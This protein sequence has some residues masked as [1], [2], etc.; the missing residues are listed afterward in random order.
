M[1]SKN[2]ITELWQAG[3]EFREVAAIEILKDFGNHAPLFFHLIQEHR[4]PLC[5][6]ARHLMP[7]LRKGYGTPELHENE[8]DYTLFQ[9]MNVLFRLFFQRLDEYLISHQQEKQ[10]L[11]NLLFQ[12]FEGIRGDLHKKYGLPI[13]IDEHEVAHRQL[14]VFVTGHCNLHCA[15][16]FSSNI[17]HREIDASA[18]HDIFKWAD[19]QKVKSITPCG[20]EPLMYQHFQLFLNL[21]KEYGMTTYF[22]TNFTIDIS[23]LEHFNQ[24]VIKGVYI[25]LTTELLEDEKLKKVVID[26]IHIAK[27]RRIEL[28]GRANIT[29]PNQD[30]DRWLSFLDDMEIKR[31]HVAL[32]IPSSLATNQYI[33][34]TAYADYVPLIMDLIQKTSEHNIAIGFAKPIPLCLFPE[35]TAR[36]LMKTGYDIMSCDIHLD[37]C[38][39]NICISP[40][41]DITPCLGLT[42]PKIHFSP[43]LTWDSIAEKYK[44]CVSTLMVAPTYAKC[45]SCFLWVRRICQGV[46]LSYKEIK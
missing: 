24:S 9:P 6:S 12:E 23:Q 38:M 19:G 46:C 2:D 40:S 14:M 17:E 28:V 37:N 8:I 20:G 3:T 30:T 7:F 31:L 22:A 32:T 21:I 16:C 4:E 36:L 25:H 44:Q 11:I 42:M 1:F 41:L 27:E 5:A 15:Y 34:T 33:D 43:S 10:T 13:T 45:E 39:H 18:L 26:N 35:E 29:H